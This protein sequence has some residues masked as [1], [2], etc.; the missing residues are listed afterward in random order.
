MFMLTFNDCKYSD[1]STM[2]R[3]RS[4][5][6]H[7]MVITLLL[8][9]LCFSAPVFAWEAEIR[10]DGEL[11]PAEIIEGYQVHNSSVETD[12]PPLSD[13]RDRDEL[14]LAWVRV[15][16]A[17][18][19]GMRIRE[20]DLARIEERK[21]ELTGNQ[22]PAESKR[23]WLLLTAKARSYWR[24]TIGTVTDDEAEAEYQRL[25]ESGDS[26]FVN[27]PFFQRVQME[28]FDEQTLQVLA[29]RL[30]GGETWRQ[31]SVDV[32]PVDWNSHNKDLWLTFDRLDTYKSKAFHAL[33]LKA[34][35]LAR[36]DVIGPL[37]EHGRYRMVVILDKTT[38]PL[39]PS[40]VKVMNR[41]KWA[42][43]EAKGDLYAKRHRALN[44]S[45]L[46]SVEVTHDGKPVSIVLEH[47]RCPG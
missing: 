32:D 30:R 6:L 31:V 10:V 24:D 33:E 13:I 9:F 28:S 18:D 40:D 3:K 37:S 38:V 41:R 25:V 27:V 16:I 39:V 29:D 20:K 36:N 42:A 8:V 4:T 22:S 14:V 45:L 21:E 34:D 19:R 35:D 23:H 26:R 2:F 17:E 1:L 44:T 43:V 12:C 5:S 46:E 15:K 47:E 7:S 11:I